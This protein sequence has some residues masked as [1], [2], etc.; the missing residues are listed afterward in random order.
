M[1]DYD[2]ID[3]DLP[4]ENSDE[5]TDM[6][7]IPKS[8]DKIAVEEIVAEMEAMEEEV[9]DD[10]EE[11][12]DPEDNTQQHGVNTDSTDINSDKVAEDNRGFLGR[13]Y[14]QLKNIL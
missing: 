13:A 7:D 12:D 2:F 9:L 11:A 14:N 1:T 5:E 4:E 8:E 6:N 3:P 10:E